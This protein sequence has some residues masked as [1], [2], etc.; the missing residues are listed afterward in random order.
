MTRR[1]G[2]AWRL[3]L[4]LV[5]VGVGFLLP[6]VVSD[7][8]LVQFANVGIYFI[9]ILGLNFLTGYSGQATRARSSSSI[10]AGTTWR[11]SR[12][13]G[14]SPGRPACSSA[15]RLCG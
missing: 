3:A 4:L 14:S 5:L 8:R 10:T 6:H 12:S 13:P 7:F 1:A 15:S 11:R 9:A 2:S